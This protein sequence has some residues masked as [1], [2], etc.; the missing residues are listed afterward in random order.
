MRLTD[1]EADGDA[2]RGG[3]GVVGEAADRAHNPEAGAGAGIRRAQPPVVGG[4]AN[5]ILN[6]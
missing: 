1:S 3:S 6:F 5:D 4:T 2:T